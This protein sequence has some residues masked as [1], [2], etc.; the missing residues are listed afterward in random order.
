M[1]LLIKIVSGLLATALLYQP[2]VAGAFFI[3]VHQPGGEDIYINA[4]QVDYIGPAP[5]G[6]RKAHSKVMVY[7]IWVFVLEKPFEI[8][9]KI[10]HVLGQDK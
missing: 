5:D 6:D 7:G 3:L 4:E 2:A 9:Q 8:K 1:K 10:D